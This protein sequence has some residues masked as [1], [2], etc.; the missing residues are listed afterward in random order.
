MRYQIAAFDHKNLVVHP[1]L[2]GI[3]SGLTQ[4]RCDGENQLPKY[5]NDIAFGQ[6]L[7]M[8]TSLA[9]RNDVVLFPSLPTE[10]HQIPR[11]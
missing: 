1:F 11:D 2:V 7:L 6:F 8:N 5:L 4:E 3:F 9:E 10:K